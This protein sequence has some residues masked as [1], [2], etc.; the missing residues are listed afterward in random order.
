MPDAISENFLKIFQIL[1][2]E[3]SILTIR[4]KNEKFSKYFRCI[5]SGSFVKSEKKHFDSKNFDN[6]AS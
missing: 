1:E 2:N 6:Q 3:W 5:Q 4:S